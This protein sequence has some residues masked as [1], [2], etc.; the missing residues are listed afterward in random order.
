MG[1]KSL[2]IQQKHKDVALIMG[3]TLVHHIMSRTV[4]MREKPVLI[5]FV[6]YGGDICMLE[7][8]EKQKY[9]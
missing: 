3:S 1:T 9:I 7:P 4:A 6:Y 5:G 2:L 8:E